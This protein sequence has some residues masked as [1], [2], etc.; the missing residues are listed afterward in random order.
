MKVE[1]CGSRGRIGSLSSCSD[2]GKRLLVSVLATVVETCIEEGQLAVWPIQR[3]VRRSLHQHSFRV[4]IP[5]LF[6]SSTPH[7]LFRFG[8]RLKQVIPPS[9]LASGRESPHPATRWGARVYFFDPTR[10]RRSRHHSSHMTN[11][12]GRRPHMQRGTVFVAQ[13]QYVAKGGVRPPR[14]SASGT[15]KSSEAPQ[16]LD[17]RG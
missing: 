15:F 2:V 11:V 13:H 1:A 16:T 17:Q 7:G 10:S 8:S 3:A 6:C 12:P 5:G 4:A 14:R 9:D